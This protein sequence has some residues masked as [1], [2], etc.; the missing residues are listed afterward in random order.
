MQENWRLADTYSHIMNL[1]HAAIAWEF[2]RRNP[3]YRNDYQSARKGDTAQLVQ[4]WG[5][6]A[7]PDL[8]ADQVLNVWLGAAEV[9]VSIVS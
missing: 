5:T 7:N 9:P 2:L 1:G 4:R 8:G 6:A 3:D